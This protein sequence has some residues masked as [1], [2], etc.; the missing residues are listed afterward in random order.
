MVLLLLFGYFTVTQAY[1]ICTKESLLEKACCYGGKNILQLFFCG[2]FFF[3]FFF[4]VS[5][6]TFNWVAFCRIKWIKIEEP[7]MVGLFCLF[8]PALLSL[9]FSSPGLF[10]LWPR[11]QSWS[12]WWEEGSR[13]GLPGNLILQNWEASYW[14]GPR[15]FSPPFC[16]SFTSWP[17][18]LLPAPFPTSQGL[19]LS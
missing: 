1:S 15:T 8:F 2:F 5:F 11:G 10:Y 16:A 19:I 12:L 13:E 14:E 18:Q 4:L 6:S 17:H 7:L 9:L 3:F